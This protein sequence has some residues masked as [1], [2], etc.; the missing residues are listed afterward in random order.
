M[1]GEDLLNDFAYMDRDTIYLLL[2]FVLFMSKSTKSILITV[3]GKSK[4]EFMS[5]SF[6]MNEIEHKQLFML[7]F[8]H[9]LFKRTKKWDSNFIPRI[10]G[11]GL[12]FLSF[13]KQTEDVVAMSR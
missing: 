7:S 6:Q 12:R 9:E 4:N 5:F 11:N 1:G 10:Q 2:F 13:Q 8:F 3:D